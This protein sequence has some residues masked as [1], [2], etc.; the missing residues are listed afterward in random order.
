MRSFVHFIPIATSL[1]SMWFGS[2]LVR[3]YRERGGKHH[4]WWGS[5][6]WEGRCTPL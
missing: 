2:L 4:F 5:F 1:F 6:S 3:R